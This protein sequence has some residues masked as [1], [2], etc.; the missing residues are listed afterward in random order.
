[1][2]N[3]LDE[4]I[5]AILAGAADETVACNPLVAEL[6]A[7]AGE[8]RAL[9]RADFKVQLKADLLAT[10]CDS[11]YIARST[12]G[13]EH[14]SDDLAAGRILPTF[15]GS[16]PSMFPVQSRSFMVSLGAHALMVALI[17]T[18]GI[19]AAQRLPE[20]PRVSST[21]VR[22]SSS[23]FAPSA[24]QAGGGGGGGSSDPLQAS[25]GNPPRFAREQIAPPSIIVRSEPPKLPAEPT[26]VGPPELSFP[27]TVHM[28]DPF[29]H[30]SGPS[31]N[32]PGSGGGIGDGERGGIGPGNGPGVGEGWAG[33]IG[34]GPYVV[35]RGVSAPRLVYDPEPEYSDE[36]RKQKYQGVVVLRVVVSDD[37]LPRDIRVAQS[38]GL[39]LDE[40]ALE[41]VRRW[42]FEPGRLNGKAVAVV[43]HIQVNFRLY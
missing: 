16:G 8:L 22:D 31:S 25:K 7:V 6:L 17:V 41:A 13:K 33:G 18:S 28:G 42:R 26:V 15:A 10:A 12:A 32:G 9:P 37:G 1:M 35:G 23:V 43:V 11:S 30:L 40:K 39:G 19:W 3:Q 27:Q 5:G 21:M 4:R 24:D 14:G 20:K 2:M 38:V 29:S 36:A 34:N